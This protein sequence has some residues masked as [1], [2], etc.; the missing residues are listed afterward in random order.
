MAKSHVL[1]SDNKPPLFSFDI[2]TE[3]KNIESWVRD[4]KRYS[5]RD[6][7]NEANLLKQIAVDF[8][9]VIETNALTEKHLSNLLNAINNGPS[10]VWEP[11]INKLQALLYYYENA[12][13]RFLEHIKIGNSRTLERLLNCISDNFST[14]ELIEIFTFTFNSK[15]KKLK[16]K[17]SEIALELRN[18]G[19]VPFLKDE[20]NRQT[21]NQV[22]ESLQFAI[23]NMWQPKG[24][25]TF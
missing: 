9:E 5:K 24:E 15:S 14:H 20:L 1:K 10:G 25:L 7:E 3:F 23:D 13:L 18:E 4:N 21:D 16:I 2:E 17:S 22:I 8:I 12:K 6:L 11:A 19:L